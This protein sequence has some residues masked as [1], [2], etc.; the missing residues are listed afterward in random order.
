MKRIRVQIHHLLTIKLKKKK[1][2]KNIWLY[3]RNL[4]QHVGLLPLKMLV[5]VL[6]VLLYTWIIN[7]ELQ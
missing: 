2:E 7:T 6:N 4:C 5:V 3:L 1:E